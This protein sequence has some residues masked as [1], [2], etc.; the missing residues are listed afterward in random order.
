MNW[1]TVFARLVAVF[2]TASVPTITVGAFM[3][4]AVLTSALQ[5]GCASVL[6][7]IMALAQSYRNDGQL[8]REEIDDAFRI[9]QD[10]F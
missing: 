4:V 10:D 3:D 6:M 8:S 1:T 7:V 5:A 2:I 9:R